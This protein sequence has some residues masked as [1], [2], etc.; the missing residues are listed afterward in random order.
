[1]HRNM[2]CLDICAD[3]SRVRPHKSGTRRSCGQTYADKSCIW[4]GGTFTCVCFVP[5]LCVVSATVV[6]YCMS[7]PTVEKDRPAL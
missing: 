3:L 7:L 2:V 4:A 6:L 5:R 1:M